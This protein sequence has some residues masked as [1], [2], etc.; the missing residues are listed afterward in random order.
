M[1]LGF[2][3]LLVPANERSRH[4]ILQGSQLLLQRAPAQLAQQTHRHRLVRVGARVRV[5]VGARVRVGVGA[6]VRVRVGAR[7][8]V[9]ARV[10]VRARV[11]ARA[12]VG[13]RVRVS[14]I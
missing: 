2:G 11:R 12:R 7:V 5:K 6:R 1:G 13:A 3:P 9:S 14:S 4:G 10:R 8:R